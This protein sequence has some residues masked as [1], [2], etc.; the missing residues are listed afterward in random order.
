MNSIGYEIDFLPVG[1][2]E[3]SGDAIALRWGYLNGNTSVEQSV[4]IIDGGFKD[5]GEA[6]VDHVQKYY[7]T[8]QVYA[9]FCTHPDRDHASGLLPVLEGLSVQN[10]IMHRPWNHTKGISDW[11]K[12]GRVTDNSV[13]EKLKDSLEFAYQLEQAAIEKEIDIIEPFTP[14]YFNMGFNSTLRILGPTEEYYETLLLDFRGTPEPKEENLLSKAFS[15]AQEA[16]S[17][18]KETIDIETL[19]DDGETAAENNSSSIL[20][21]TIDSNSLLFTGDAGIPAL[22]QAISLLED[23]NFD[24]DKIRFIQVPHHGSSR[25]IEPSILDKIIGPKLPYDE[26][27]KSAFVSAAKNGAPKHPSRKVCNAFRRRG[28][29]VNGTMGKKIWHYHN[30]PQRSDYCSSVPL[31]FYERVEE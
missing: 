31:P 22:T 17:W 9:V 30:A 28:A 19:D 7:K 18:V 26:K 12:D 2:G 24:F 8:D 15:F 11:F 29:P 6:L 27:K 20:L 23:D 10:L 3:K 5:S 4:A 16:V 14:K 13:K 21:F 1:V 25:N